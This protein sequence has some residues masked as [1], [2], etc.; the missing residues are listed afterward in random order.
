MAGCSIWVQVKEGKP[1]LYK[2]DDDFPEGFVAE[3]LTAVHGKCSLSV[4]ADKLSMYR[5]KNVYDRCSDGELDDQAFLNG[6]L[7]E[8]FREGNTY[9]NPFYVHYLDAE[10]PPPKKTRVEEASR[11]IVTG[12]DF[13]INECARPT[14]VDTKRSGLVGLETCARAC[15]DVVNEWLP[16]TT[17]ASETRVPPAMLSRCMRGGK[18]TLLCKVFDD[19]KAAGKSPIFISFNGD[20]IIHRLPDEGPLDTMLRAIA[21]ALMKDKPTDSDTASNLR[22][23][24]HTVRRYLDGKDDVVLLV[25]ELNVL[26]K[27]SD[28]ETYEDVGQFLRETFLD[29]DS[30]HLVSSTH[31]PASAGI[32]RLLGTGGGRSRSAV[33]ISMPVG[34]LEELQGMHQKCSNL[35]PC[36]AAYY[37]YIPSLIFTVKVL[38]YD[39]PKRFVE[40]PKPVA[41]DELCC[42]FLKELF[43]GKRVGDDTPVRAFDSLTTCPKDGE[44]QWVLGYAGLMCDYLGFKEVAKMI[45]SLKVC[46]ESVGSGKDWEL[47]SQI[48]LALRCYET[49]FGEAHCGLQLPA[50]RTTDFVGVELVPSKFRNP[51]GALEW[52]KDRAQHLTAFP[53][54][55]FLIPQHT[56]FEHFDSIIVRQA[57]LSDHPFVVGFQNELSKDYPKKDVP[58]GMQGVLLRG[59]APAKGRGSN[60]FSRWTY[61]TSDE[62]IDILGASLAPMYPAN[63]AR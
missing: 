42:Q 23:D 29:P 17:G 28:T 26:L 4:G 51:V 11:R 5:S 57:R 8:E 52:W 50:D 62:L 33:A 44:I 47:I 56:A 60:N 25:D 20:T 38:E 19:L 14:S 22:C 61:S 9:E 32:D 1:L 45:G 46:A 41:N 3:L 63:W 36:E 58:E 43:T 24:K 18:T 2:K 12:K 31:V 40:L 55:S 13:D 7:V 21:V 15:V 30:R 53:H 54:I 59:D 48:A 6:R 39:F 34:T 35:T 16:K 37:S 10:E 27:P 49:K